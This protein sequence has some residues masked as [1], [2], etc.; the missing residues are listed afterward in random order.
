[1]EST[2]NS[3]HDY[4]IIGG[5]T[6][7]CVL[8]SRLLEHNSSLSV[9]VMEAGSDVT[10]HPH[11]YKPLEAAKLHFSDIDYKYFTTPQVHLDGKPR[12]ACGVKAL[13]GAVAINSGG[14]IRGDASDYAQWAHQA[15]DDRWTYQGLLPY[16][17]RSEHHFEPNADPNHHGF[18]GP[19]HTCSVTS[20]GRHYPLRETILNAWK[21]IGL[22]EVADAN[23]GAPQ[24]VAELVENRCDG[25]RQLTSVAYPLTGAQ[26]MTETYVAR[27]TLDD[28]KLGKVTT[29]V[30]LAD[31]RRL[32]I[33]EGG[34]VLLCG[35]AYRSPQI[36]ILS[37]I[38]GKHILEEQK[39]PQAIDLPGVGHNL[40]DHQMIF[41]YWKLRH[42]EKGL[43]M[44]SPEFADPAFE[45]GN[46]VDWIATMTVPEDGL[47]AAIATDVG[48]TLD[49]KAHPSLQGGRSHLELD[50]LYATFGA[51]Q[52]ELEIPVDGTAIMSHCMACLP[53]S[54]GSITISSKDP[55]AAPVIDPN[56]CA[57][58]A[59]RH[60][61]RQGWRTMSRLMLE[62]PEG[63]DL[64]AEEI[65]PEGHKCLQSDACDQDIDARIKIGGM[66]CYHPA[67]SCSM[68]EVVD[69][70]CKVYGVQGLRVVD[71]SVIPVPVAAH[72]QA[73]VFALA[74]QAADIIIADRKPSIFEHGSMAQ[75]KL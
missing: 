50:V 21:S 17:R 16:F 27:I 48:K 12:Y 35:G 55:T 41:R 18:Q 8:A 45:K 58:E 46:P 59:D 31:G 54:R 60:V 24:G 56:Y 4:I 57:T 14:W 64:V 43:A 2:V 38:G 44:G 3:S 22:K 74:E 34:G 40:H 36:L 6:A 37:G 19:M 30:E 1:M 29:G 75:R 20:S 52:I 61:M 15:G 69:S 13:S 68:G 63:K 9:V 33:K 62:T 26:I 23:N 51:E 65:L 67:G 39:I 28:N 7:A 70:S 72:Y 11:I 47:Q 73:P 71:A 49:D 5:G 53:S 25:L 42:P 32:S 10:D 66:S